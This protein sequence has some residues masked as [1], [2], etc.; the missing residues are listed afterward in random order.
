MRIET[1]TRI[2]EIDAA[3]W[4]GLR[5]SDNPFLRHEFLVAL[6]RHGC[7]G[8]ESGWLPC[9]LVVRA[10]SKDG[11]EES[12]APPAGT[13]LAAAPA[14]I[15]LNS[16]G[17]FVFDWAW[18]SAYERAGRA[19]YPKLVVAV[20]YT[21]VSGH[22][23]LV[24][25]PAQATAMAQLFAAVTPDL[26]EQL[27]LSGVH[28]LFPPEQENEL[29]CRGGLIR[30][31][32]CQYHWSNQ[33][34][35]DFDHFLG[36]LNAQ[37]RKKIKRERRRVQEGGVE[38][39]IRHGDELAPAEWAV[40]HEL[41]RSTFDRKSGYPTLTLPFFREIG[42]TMGRQVVV[43]MALHQGKVVAGAINLRSDDALFGRHWGCFEAFH[44]LHFEACYYQGL[45]YAIAEGL[46][47]FE[48]GAQGEHKIARGFLPTKT[49]SA[50]WLHDPGFR[51]PIAAY[52]QHEE[53]A[54]R[55]ECEALMA[56]SPYRDEQ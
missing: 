56:S 28:W 26:A 10:E 35:D 39:L 43:V 50:H 30:R 47:R 19:Y 25:D 12:A 38:L 51:K 41:Y 40:V 36:R 18:A 22:R 49:W 48:P 4:N 1:V 3:E 13:L 23:I 55:A 45:D 44:S 42:R 11:P 31:L 53:E 17:E 15:K 16:Y 8:Q 54:M 21:P 24:R 9:H 34:Y 6:E 32:G 5:G 27:R 7:V 33:G 14:Y 37:K 20:P 29:L 46:A 52:C 2:E